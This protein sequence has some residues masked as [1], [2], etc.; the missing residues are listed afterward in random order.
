[1]KGFARFVDVDLQL[2]CVYAL[3]RATGRGEGTCVDN[4]RNTYRLV[5]IRASADLKSKRIDESA[6]QAQILIDG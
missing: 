6:R 1:M 5:S 4:Q 2:E 3:T